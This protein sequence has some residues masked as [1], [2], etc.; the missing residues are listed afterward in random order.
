M[1]ACLSQAEFAGRA[2]GPP[3]RHSAKVKP[4]VGSIPA[5]RSGGTTVYGMLDNTLQRPR[6]T[7][8]SAF[9]SC[10]A[11]KAFL[12]KLMTTAEAPRA[13]LPLSVKSL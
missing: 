12:F 4:Y 3:P 6:G 13:E 7:I 1:T 5:L 9:G 11:S 2:N 10:N 8:S